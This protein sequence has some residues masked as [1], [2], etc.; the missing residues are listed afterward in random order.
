MIAAEI[1]NIILLAIIMKTPIYF[2]MFIHSVS[3]SDY[4]VIV[5]IIRDTVQYL[6]AKTQ[7]PRSMQMTEIVANTLVQSMKT[8]C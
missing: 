1:L 3:L 8:F 6:V 5:V 2:M 7:Y 4:I